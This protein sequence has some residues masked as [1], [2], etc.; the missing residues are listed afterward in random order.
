MDN[1][2]FSFS[3]TDVGKKRSVNQDSIYVDDQQKIWVVAD[4]MGGHR[5]GDKASQAIVAAFAN[6]TLTNVMSQRI[7]TIEKTIRSLNAHLQ[8]YSLNELKGQHIG[9]TIVLATVC[10]GMLAILWAG[11]SRCYR[12]NNGNIKQLTWDHSYVDELLRAGHMVA[13]EAATSKLSNV[14]TRAVGAHTELFFD[15]ILM[16]FSD[17]D[18]FLLCSDG[19][20]NELSDKII[21]SVVSQQGCSQHSL[22][23]LLEQTLEHGAKDNV[24]II[25]ISSRQRR[26]RNAQETSLITKFSKNVN[27]IATTLFDRDIDFDNYYTQI[28]KIINQAVSA[29]SEFKGQDTQEIPSTFKVAQAVKQT[30]QQELPTVNYPK[31]ST[32]ETMKHRFDP[33]YVILTVAVVLLSSTLLYFMFN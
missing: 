30:Q 23:V 14:I 20:T 25:L 17:E 8:N 9:S 6:M 31:I 11:D 32:T 10:Q 28:S 27:S 21:N 3:V 13:E 4:G 33:T 15:H 2:W 12:M 26:P 29:H 22:D 18:T 7:L 19:L 5:D 24:S 1:N 16:P